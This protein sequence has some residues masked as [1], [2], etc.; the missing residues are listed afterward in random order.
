MSRIFAAPPRLKH[1]L[2]GSGVVLIGVD[3]GG[4]GGG[5]GPRW[6]LRGAQ[7]RRNVSR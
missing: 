2:K 6:H 1:T 7:P 4:V 5:N 3:R